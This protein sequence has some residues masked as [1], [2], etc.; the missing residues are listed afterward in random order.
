MEQVWGSTEVAAIAS[1]T[2]SWSMRQTLFVV[3]ALERGGDDGDILIQA[4]GRAGALRDYEEAVLVGK[5]DKPVASLELVHGES[6]RICE[7]DG[8]R[9]DKVAPQVDI[10]VRGGVLARVGGIGRIVIGAWRVLA[11]GAL[12][13]AGAIERDGVVDEV[14]GAHARGARLDLDRG[15][16]GVDGDVEH[17]AAL[18]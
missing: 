13:E 12:L 10:A 14:R 15:V 1:M 9:V 5:A 4:L 8:A 18:G 17:G 2:P 6:R 11:G 7:L 3:G 16:H